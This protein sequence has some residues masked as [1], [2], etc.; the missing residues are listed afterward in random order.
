[1]PKNS[2][3]H[4]PTVPLAVLCQENLRQYFAQI[5]GCD[6]T[7]VYKLIMGEIEKTLLESALAHCQQNQSKTA[8]ILG[9]S[10]GTLRKKI[11]LHDLI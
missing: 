1:M 6:A 9:I 11:V 2:T 4:K 8:K 7:G 5:D 3:A 10:R